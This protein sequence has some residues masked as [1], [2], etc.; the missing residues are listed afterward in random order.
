[1]LKARLQC[2]DGLDDVEALARTGRA[3]DDVDTAVAQA[4]GIENLIA[5]LDFFDR[6]RRQGHTDCVA[7]T[8]PQ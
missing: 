6:V 2:L 7:N 8:H 4:E 5:D 1:M 3:R